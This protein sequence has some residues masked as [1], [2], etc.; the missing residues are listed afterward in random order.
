MNVFNRGRLRL[1]PSTLPATLEF[2][3]RDSKPVT[4]VPSGAHLQARGHSSRAVLSIT[5]TFCR[6]RGQEVVPSLRRWKVHV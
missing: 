3:E 6:I 2:A 1:S 4:F 5:M